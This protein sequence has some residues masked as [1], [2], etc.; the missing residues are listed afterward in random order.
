MSTWTAHTTV[1]AE[2]HTVLELLTD[3][4]AIERWSPIPFE[5][6]SLTGDRLESGVHARVA[7][8]LGRI[9][10]TFDVEVES[11]REERFALT[12]QGPLDLEVDYELFPAGDGDTEVW[13]S[14][15]VAS[16]GGLSGRLLAQA[17]EA[18]LRAGALDRALGR[19]AA[20]IDSHH[21]E[22]ND[23]SYARVA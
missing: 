1:A 8:R 3:P 15:G 17:T 5:I 4:D 6:G 20:E 21:E 19:I 13:V 22:I 23:D 10:A 11:A 16:G 7:G 12:A 9:G 2:P 14:L 18:L